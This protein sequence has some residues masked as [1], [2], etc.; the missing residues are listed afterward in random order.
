MKCNFTLPSCFLTG[1]DMEYQN[2]A[3][4]TYLISSIWIKAW[5]GYSTSLILFSLEFEISIASEWEHSSSRYA[6]QYSFKIYLNPQ[7]TLVLSELVQ[8]LLFKLLLFLNLASFCCQVLKGHTDNAEFA[9]N[10]SRAAPYVL[11]GG[12]VCFW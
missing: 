6:C 2:S 12:N 5:S 1:S 7:R 8:D 9:L 11:S 4:P 3:K 10:L